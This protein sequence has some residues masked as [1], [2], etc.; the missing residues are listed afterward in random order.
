MISDE[1]LAD[2]VDKVKPDLVIALRAIMSGELVHIFDFADGKNS[3]GIRSKV[4]LFMA[5]EI[6]A[7]IL[8]GTARGLQESAKIWQA[9]LEGAAIDVVAQYKKAAAGAEPS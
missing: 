5:E 1:Q 2:L 8:E 7:A 4:V 3:Q 9:R 6:S